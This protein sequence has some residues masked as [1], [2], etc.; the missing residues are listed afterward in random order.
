[1]TNQMHLK[2]QVGA[3]ISG[4]RNNETAQPESKSFKYLISLTL[5]NL[6]L[7]LSYTKQ[8]CTSIPK[9]CASSRT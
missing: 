4:I 8:K 9:P 3:G 7:V 1:M 5:T 2:L 6:T